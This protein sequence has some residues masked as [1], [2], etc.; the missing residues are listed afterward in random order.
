MKG[1]YLP[2]QSWLK[3]KVFKLETGHEITIEHNEHYGEFVK[4]ID[5][6]GER[7]V[8]CNG[9]RSLPTSFQSFLGWVEPVSEHQPDQKWMV[10]KF[11]RVY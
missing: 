4:S 3:Q 10:P 11:Q 9:L 6:D 5:K 7:W 8:S 1:K 2:E